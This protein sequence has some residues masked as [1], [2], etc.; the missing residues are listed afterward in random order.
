MLQRRRQVVGGEVGE[1][2]KQSSRDE[3][4]AACCGETLRQE[5]SFLESSNLETIWSGARS[6]GE[7]RRKASHSLC[8]DQRPSTAS[9]QHYVTSVDSI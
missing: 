2:G 5:P 6:V 3:N 7:A 4:Q 9:T 8:P 1:S